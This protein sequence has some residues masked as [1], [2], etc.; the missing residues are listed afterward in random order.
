MRKIINPNP[1]PAEPM[2]KGRGSKIKL[3]NTWL[4]TDALDVHLTRLVPGGPRG[5]LHKHS[6]ADNVYIVR[7]GQGDLVADGKVHT[8]RKDQVIFIPAGMPHSLSNVADEPFEI[9][10]I[11]AP[12]G[13]T[14]DFI[15]C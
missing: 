13:S 12:A 4:G 3:V 9:F 6:E 14:F 11:Y 1:A 8:V 5:S 7:S 2:E 10:E 15:A